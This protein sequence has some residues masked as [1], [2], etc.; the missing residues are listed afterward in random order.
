MKQLPVYT[1]YLESIQEKDII[2]TQEPGVWQ[3]IKNRMAYGDSE[4]LIF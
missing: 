4:L 1:E 3:L 2:A